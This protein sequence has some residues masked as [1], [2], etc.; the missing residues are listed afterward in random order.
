MNKQAHEG[1]N[2]QSTEQTVEEMS[3]G[4]DAWV[5]D[6]LDACWQGIVFKLG[7]VPEG[8]PFHDCPDVLY[9][10]IILHSSD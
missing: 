7:L 3:K 1:M 9:L 8:R 4:T 6:H 5:H 2:Q 10:L